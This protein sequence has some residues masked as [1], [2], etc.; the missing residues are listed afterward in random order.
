M[1]EALKTVQTNNFSASSGYYFT[2]T[3][4]TTLSM[5]LHCH[6]PIKDASKRTLS[7]TTAKVK[8]WIG[9]WI[10]FISIKYVFPVPFSCILFL[11]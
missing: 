2:F 7:Y 10:C 3:T 1:S 11:V 5:L 9:I 6:I 4:L 8:V